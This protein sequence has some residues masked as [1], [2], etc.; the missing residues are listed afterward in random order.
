LRPFV[1]PTGTRTCF[2]AREHFQFVI[3]PSES[4]EAFLFAT[5]HCEIVATAE[6]LST[7][8]TSARAR[9]PRL[10]PV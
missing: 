1:L 5:H 7:S 9:P 10:D 6:G 3:L 2:A 4:G 8:S